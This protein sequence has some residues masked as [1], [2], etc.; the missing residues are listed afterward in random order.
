MSTTPNSCPLCQRPALRLNEDS[1]ML[2]CASCGAQAEFDGEARRVRYTSLPVRYAQFEG[3]LR[4]R[5]LARTEVFAAVAAAQHT[6]KQL[7]VLLVTLGVL[8]LMGLAFLLTRNSPA[9]PLPR[10]Q[11]MHSPETL[12][13]AV[14]PTEVMATSTAVLATTTPATLPTNAAAVNKATE[15]VTASPTN[16]A[17]VPTPPTEAATLA[18]EPIATTVSPTLQPLAA[19]PVPV[20][21]AGQAA[22]T[23]S[24]APTQVA[25]QVVSQV[26][27][28][29]T[30][31]GTPTARV[32][33]TPVLVNTPLPVQTPTPALGSDEATTAP[34]ATSEPTIEPTTPPTETP[35]PTPTPAPTQ[36]PTPVAFSISKIAYVGGSSSEENLEMAN[37]TDQPMDIAINT[38]RLRISTSAGQVELKLSDFLRA[39]ISIP[40][41][42]SCRLYTSKR[43][44]SADEQSPCGFLTLGIVDDTDGIYPNKPGATVT[45]LDGEGVRVATFRY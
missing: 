3:A 19:T 24:P 6:P 1:T 29:A 10:K 25:S 2:I 41:R 21:D 31:P 32:A 15:Q 26:V 33:N 42:Q 28:L 23:V 14:A 11:T 36:T 27:A 40:A 38:W 37:A 12:A 13:P 18:A 22:A 44:P 43:T 39:P 35:I 7:P 16:E 34:T 9:Q 8:G 20:V 4:G 5:W 30:V 17:V 45:L